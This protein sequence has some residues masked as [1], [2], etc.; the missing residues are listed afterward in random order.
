MTGIPVYC[1]VF[2][3]TTTTKRGAALE[4]K[5]EGRRSMDGR[6][7]GWVGMGMDGMGK[8]STGAAASRGSVA[9]FGV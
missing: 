6:I 2:A 4:C 9:S 7:E 1:C 5:Q 8:A 3:T